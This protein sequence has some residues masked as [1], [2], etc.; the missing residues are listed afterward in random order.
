MQVEN[1]Q[2]DFASMLMG[3]FTNQENP[4]GISDGANDGE[5][6]FGSSSSAGN[7]RVTDN[8]KNPSES[9]LTDHE[10]FVHMDNGDNTSTMSLNSMFSSMQVISNYIVLF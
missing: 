1:S 4:D 3:S 9:D 2:V 5:I 7:E 8:R 10:D 6:L